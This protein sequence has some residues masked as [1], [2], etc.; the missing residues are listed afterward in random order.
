V[1]EV[2][3]EDPF[4]ALRLIE[5]CGVNRFGHVLIAVPPQKVHEFADN[6]DEAIALT[7]AVI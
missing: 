7:F 1:E 2:S 3:E 4:A 5:V 6:R